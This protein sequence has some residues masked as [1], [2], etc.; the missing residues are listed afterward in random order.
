MKKILSIVLGVA[1]ISLAS[2]AL[3][4]SANP[5]I[6][7]TGKPAND[8]LG[9]SD[10][11]ECLA[12]ARA[13]LGSLISLL[14]EAD[15]ADSSEP[16]F[17]VDVAETP[18]A[19]DEKP[20]PAQK[21]VLPVYNAR[22]FDHQAV[23]IPF[24]N[25]IPG[26]SSVITSVYQRDGIDFLWVSDIAPVGM[27]NWSVLNREFGEIAD[28]DDHVW[29]YYYLTVKPDFY[30]NKVTA[31]EITADEYHRIIAAYSAQ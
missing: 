3:N 5:I 25:N 18:P 7:D 10:Y 27:F 15:D 2:C 26:G 1:V 17:T 23:I 30:Q 12:E 28:S 8:N 24:P 20:A 29:G 16:S 19:P 4:E 14:D 31:V 22:L 21:P 11:N 6:N 13:D 9:E